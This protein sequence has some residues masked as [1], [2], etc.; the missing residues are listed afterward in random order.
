[1]PNN[2]DGAMTKTFVMMSVMVLL[3]FGCHK[4][5]PALNTTGK[6]FYV[7]PNG[8]D[9]NPGTEKEPFA[10]L[11]KAKTAVRGIKADSQ[12]DIVVYFRGG[13]YK[14]DKPVIFGHLDSA[15]AACRVIYTN[16]PGEKPVFSGGI[17]PAKWEHHDGNIYK[18]FAGKDLDFRQIYVNNKKA[19]RA[20]KPNSDRLY[21]FKTEKGADGFDIPKGLLEGVANLKDVELSIMNKWMHKRLRV[22]N[23]YEADGYTRAVIN[24]IEWKAILEGP[25]AIRNYSGEEYWLENAY[26]FIDT[27]G[28]WYLNRSDGYLYYWPQAGEDISTAEV[29]VPGLEQMII[30]NG[31]FDN[32]VENLTF[33]G[34][35]FNCTNWTRPNEY[36][37]VDVYCNTLVPI[38]ANDK[39]DP[40][41]RH[42]QRKDRIPSA[43]YA[44]ASNSITV[45]GC[46]FKHLGGTGLTFDYGGTDNL[47]EG[48]VF[49]DI[50]GS[51]VEVGNDANKPLDARMIPKRITIRN[52][53]VENIANDYYGGL[54]ITVFYAD[55]LL[56]EHNYINN[57][58][59]SG[60]GAGWG[61]GAAEATELNRD[62]TIRHNRVED[63]AKKLTDGGGIYT[64]NP[65]YGVNII[66]ENYIKGN[67]R[68]L[69]ELIIIGIY[70]DGASSN[71]LTRNNVIEFVHN[72]WIGGA[73]FTP[74]IKSNITV[75]NN[76]TTILK[77]RLSVVIPEGSKDIKP[78]NE[79]NVII[80]NTQV[81]EDADWPQPAREIIKK[82]GLQPQWQ[83]II[84]YANKGLPQ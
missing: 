68:S 56:I 63:Y 19:I 65:V 51:G 50:S 38:P 22:I 34:L 5:V 46:V 60:I 6:V 2:K 42:N 25:Q 47:I 10:T 7:S 1:M 66:E 26:E 8:K 72:W 64:P 13:E 48:N 40:Q 35:E 81:Y 82:S 18:A 53:Y 59:Y 57:V 31:T 79:R 61:W 67:A 71:W 37:F 75:D 62:F 24:P 84:P 58:P 30:L 39:V 73:S 80:T 74:Q 14:M 43:F 20:R 33:S 16:Y 9:Q 41:Y 83:Y 12:G 23:A 52:N 32:P 69:T 36:G 70:H 49:I 78:A 54:G 29:T 17:S 45:S 15:N 55:T 44:V 11:E 77:D 76:Y 21:T 3:F 27:P 28:E 4:G